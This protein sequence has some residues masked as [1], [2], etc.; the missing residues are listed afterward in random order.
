MLFTSDTTH[1]AFFPNYTPNSLFFHNKLLYLI[2]FIEKL[3]KDNSF[4]TYT[5]FSDK[6]NAKYDTFKTKIYLFLFKEKQ[7][8]LAFKSVIFNT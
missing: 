1:F 2:S 3:S 4:S 8:D 5:K 6:P 7:V